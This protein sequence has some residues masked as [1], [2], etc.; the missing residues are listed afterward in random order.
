[1]SS[2]K[3]K[4]RKL[5][6]G[7]EIKEKNDKKY[8]SL[9]TGE[10]V[11]KII[12]RIFETVS[13]VGI[14]EEREE[15]EEHEQL[16]KV[17][18]STLKR[19][20]RNLFI[21][22]EKEYQYNISLHIYEKDK[23]HLSSPCPYFF[24]T[25]TDLDEN[26]FY[27]SPCGYESKHHI[28]LV[29]ETE[30]ENVLGFWFL[31]NESCLTKQNNSY[32][33]KCC[34]IMS[35]T[36]KTNKSDHKCYFNIDPIR[37]FTYNFN[38]DNV[39]IMIL[40]TE[41]TGIYENKRHFSDLISFDSARILQIA[42]R[43]CKI[44]GS[45][46]NGF[47]DGN[48]YLKFE[49]NEINNIK[50]APEAYGLHN[51]SISTVQSKGIPRI[52]W[53]EIFDIALN[54]C[55]YI[56]GHNISFDISVIASE[57]YRYNQI[58]LIRK[59]LSKH[60]ICTMKIGYHICPQIR[61]QG[62][63]SS[64]KL[65]ELYEHYYNKIPSI[66]H[67]AIDDV[68][69][70]HKIWIKMHSK[71]K[72]IP[73]PSQEQQVIID[74]LHF[75]YNIMVNA[76]AG[77]GK[78]TTILQAA[79]N[80]PLKKFLVITYNQRLK[81]ETEERCFFSGIKNVKV[82]TYHGAAN[83]F[84]NLKTIRDDR[85]LSVLVNE[86]NQYTK[87]K[88][89]KRYYPD[90]IVIDEAQD[91]NL[92]YYK[93]IMCICGD[94]NLITH[95]WWIM[96]DVMQ[97]INEYN[98]ADHRFLTLADKIFTSS[99]EW[100][101]LNL[102][103]SYRLT[104][105]MSRLINR[106]YIKKSYIETVKNGPL[107]KYIMVDYFNVSKSSKILSNV[108]EHLLVMYKPDDIF[109]LCPTVNQE[110]VQGVENNLVIKNIP[111]YVSRNDYSQVNPSVLSGKIVFS[112]FNQSKG[113]ER[114]CCMVFNVD[115][116]YE[117]YYSK[118]IQFKIQNAMY[119]ALTRAQENLILIH[120]S[121]NNFPSYFNLEKYDTFCNDVELIGST[122]STNSTITSPSTN[123]IDVNVTDLIKHVPERILCNIMKD[124]ICE[125]DEEEEEEISYQ[126]INLPSQ[127]L[128]SNLT[129]HVADV[130]G[131]AITMY[132]EYKMIGKMNEMYIKEMLL[133]NQNN[134]YDEFKNCSWT[135]HTDFIDLAINID[136]IQ[137]NFI[138][139][140]HQIKQL[141]WIDEKVFD[142]AL[143]NFKKHIKKFNYEKQYCKFEVSFQKS[144]KLHIDEGGDENKTSQ[145]L[146]GRVDFLVLQ[147]K[148]KYPHIW[149]LKC[150]AQIEDCHILQLAIY[151]FMVGVETGFLLNLCLDKK[152]KVNI[153]RENMKKHITTLL[154]YKYL[155]KHLL[156][157]NDEIFIKKIIP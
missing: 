15:R 58:N 38:G 108:I 127:T 91:M 105:Q 151:L 18:T 67:Q 120:D 126:P 149:E 84:Y 36:S 147:T 34:S 68:D 54:S 132:I 61:E 85:D 42:W 19:H 137:T 32:C 109:I 110:I 104:N 70:C 92:I 135:K 133:N 37:P 73:L 12:K 153:S 45:S 39:N 66:S 21:Q 52:K 69:T 56:L 87:I 28:F 53:C 145:I 144:F 125:E 98:D 97:K 90:A 77:S 33:F 156:D 64:P 22:F 131:S 81:I 82:F 128:Q 46:I 20:V 129:E 111:C 63:L 139:R 136:A 100:K 154:E 121:R 2:I 25:K 50:C 30:N 146:N 57:L 93:T 102:K 35:K 86:R 107:P 123:E 103:T 44:N 148:D 26:V 155:Q 124:I 71:F 95:Q 6:F 47:E 99:K 134:F 143:Q 7:I 41:T 17:K 9:T 31:R 80:S 96:G 5:N 24:K 106:Y 157:D 116:S 27:V 119:V 122:N 140:R 51:I 76:V 65:F 16:N 79:K 23:S 62:Y 117:K 29:V 75:G 114:K 150:T 11:E 83:F 40:D 142:C 141:N 4:Q 115:Q 14:G 118:K 130:N 152:I 101:Q 10:D 3:Y 88:K 138:N 94:F 59:L 78:T 113:L 43:I 74:S 60:F 49:P 13:N 1:M 8:F 112:S 89:S 48:Y 72:N 55:E